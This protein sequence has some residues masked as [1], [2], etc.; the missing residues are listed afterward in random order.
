MTEGGRVTRPHLC[1]H[2]RVRRWLFRIL[3]LL[4]LIS[5]AVLLTGRW[6]LERQGRTTPEQIG[7]GRAT[8]TLDER[9]IPTLRAD[10]WTALAEAQGYL[11]ASERM[12]QMDLLR[13]YA[14]GS[15]AEL[16]GSAAIEADRGRRLEDWAGYAAR[17]YQALPADERAFADAYASGVNRF[18]GDHRG[19]WG[20]EYLLLR[21]E[22]ARWR[23]ADTVL[24]LLSMIEQLTSSSRN[25]ALGGQWKA[26]LGPAWSQFLFTL[27]H[28]WNEPMFGTPARQGPELPWSEALPMAPLAADE[29]ALPPPEAPKALGRGTLD[30]TLADL[31]VALPDPAEEGAAIGS[32][33]WAYCGKRGCFVCNDP[34][35]GFTVPQVWYALRLERSAEEWALG[36]SL[37]GIPGIVLG[38]NPHLAWAF[39]NVGED[40]DDLLIETLSADGTR[41]L[42]SRQGA[43]EVW[44][45]ITTVT[46]T[47]IV[48][49]EASI[50]VTA[51]FTERGP[52]VP[53]PLGSEVGTCARHWLAFEAGLLRL[54][55]GIMRARSWEE[56]NRALDDMRMPA[57][58]VL[59]IDRRGGMGYRTSGTGVERRIDG[60]A[61][62]PALE[63]AWIAL[64][65]AAS[66][67][68]RWI[69]PS[70]TT[71][72]FLATANERI[73]VS[74]LGHSW[75]D[76]A[77]KDRIRTVLGSSDTLGVDDMLSLQLDTTSR[78]ARWLLSWIGER[79]EPKSEAERGALERWRKFDGNAA[80]DPRTF[81]EALQ[82]ESALE[83]ILLGRVRAQRLPAALRNLKTA[84]RLPRAWMLATLSVENGTR[85]FG[86]DERDLAARLLAIGAAVPSSPGYAREN[87]WAAQHP[88][89]GRVPLIGDLF[90]ISAPPQIGSR[91]VPRVETPHFGASMRVVWSVF[92]PEESRWSFPVGQSG[93]PASPHYEDARGDWIAGRARPAWSG[94]ER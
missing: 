61:P 1:H 85:V 24:I 6:Y 83:R 60:T 39:T 54:P 81:G 42:A 36:V 57:Q 70:S 49:G 84:H 26:A 56:M 89:Y 80:V 79:A 45:P 86:I 38:M 64:Q 20:A 7:G 48:K 59:M 87:S 16:F 67:P 11:V 18:I 43:R 30:R 44:A 33:S 32:N 55:P 13:R 71:S 25:D 27:D 77:R 76:D 47:I 78:F 3:A 21:T 72:Y 90:G 82:V 12:F 68:R 73:W 91:H 2:A 17:A 62:Q 31:G 14:G 88:F 10:D 51:R 69:A 58:N 50:P 5:A 65:P 94:A 22:P 93:H 29:G 28:P 92:A 46:S 52:L 66:R 4:V 15:L 37:P 63:G 53:C 35:L 19:A 40:V 74:E 9:A 34:H 75:S 23:G 41:Y 8:V